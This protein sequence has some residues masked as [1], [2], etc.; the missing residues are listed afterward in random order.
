MLEVFK[1]LMADHGG[2][3]GLVVAIVFAIMTLVSAIIKVL[4]LFKKKAPA[5][6]VKILAGLQWLLDFI[7]A[8]TAHKAVVEKAQ[9]DA[10]KK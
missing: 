1:E 2:F 9:E 4:E 5:P 6:L 10:E 3:V 7:T 8:N